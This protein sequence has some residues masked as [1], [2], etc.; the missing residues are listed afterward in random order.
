MSPSNNDGSG[1]DKIRDCDK[2]LRIKGIVR[3]EVDLDMLIYLIGSVIMACITAGFVIWGFKTEQFKE[4]EHLKRLALEE[5]E[6]ENED[7]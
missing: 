5:A 3:L 6:E 4:N 1:E 7:A 2:R